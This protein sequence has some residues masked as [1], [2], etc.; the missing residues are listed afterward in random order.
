MFT[1]HH[2]S[3][4]T[5]HVSG[6]TCHLSHVRCHVFFCFFLQRGEASWLRV[7]YQ[8]GLH[9]LVYVNLGCKTGKTVFSLNLMEGGYFRNNI[10]IIRSFLVHVTLKKN[11]ALW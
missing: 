11:H 2:V 4:V 7:C 10:W 1:P 6:V 5:C 3:Y 8:R 9:H